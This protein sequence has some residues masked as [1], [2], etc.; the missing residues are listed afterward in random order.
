MA[1]MVGQQLYVDD[2]KLTRRTALNVTVA[3]T[4]WNKLLAVWP[5]FGADSPQLIGMTG[6]VA[7][8]YMQQQAI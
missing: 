7:I 8:S 1:L 5:E 2:H 6:P 4:L 3:T